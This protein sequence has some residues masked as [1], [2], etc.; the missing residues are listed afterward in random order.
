MNDGSFFGG[1]TTKDPVAGAIADAEKY[2]FPKRPLARRLTGL[3][4]FVIT[5]G[6]EYCF[7]TGLRALQWLGEL[8]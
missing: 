4:R 3:S 7:L 8:D 5:R 2:S 6:G 1:G